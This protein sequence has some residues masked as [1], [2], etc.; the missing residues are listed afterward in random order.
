MLE[1]LGHVSMASVG[2]SGVEEA[3]AVVVS[4]E[5]EIGEAFH[6]ERGL[7]RVMFGADG[8]GAHGEAAG[9]DA[10]AAESDCVGG[11]EFRGESC[12]REACEYGFGAEPGR[13]DARCGANEEFATV[14][15]SLLNWRAVRMRLTPRGAGR[16]VGLDTHGLNPERGCQQPKRQGDGKEDN[17]E[18]P[19]NRNTD[20]A[21]RQQYQPD[22]WIGDQGE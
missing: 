18:Y 1:H 16:K 5:Q 13:S 11:G 22:E 17:L 15:G 4:V 12:V 6:A 8:A 14:H 7:M 10:G 20:D 9:L 19:M 21:E 2:V 3:Q